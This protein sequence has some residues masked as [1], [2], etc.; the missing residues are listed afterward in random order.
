MSW[1]DYKIVY[2]GDW[3]NCEVEVQP[4]SPSGGIS[5]VKPPHKISLGIENYTRLA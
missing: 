2:R 1:Y 3:R 5:D 4:G